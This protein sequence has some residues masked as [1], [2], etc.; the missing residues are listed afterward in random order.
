MIKIQTALI[1]VSDK[2]G[3]ARFAA[4]LSELGVQLIST[5]GTARTLQE[6]G[7]EIIR[8]SERTGF[9]EILDGRVK[10][11]HPRIHAAI[12]ARHSDADHLRTLEEL[13]IDPI[14]LVVVNLYP[15]ARTIA[16]SQV[17]RAQAIEKIDIGGPTLVR[18]AAKNSDSI[19]VVVERED[20]PRVIAEMKAGDG[21]VSLPLR[22]DLAA[23][24]F[25]HTAAY[26]AAIAA[27]LESSG[28]SQPDELPARVALNLGKVKTLRYGEN[29][30]QRAGL[31]SSGKTAGL[32]AGV[33]HQ[34]KDLSFNNLVDMDSAWQLC[35]EFD[36]T[37]CCII[38]HNNPCGAAVADSPAPAFE[39]ALECD[40]VSAFGSVIAFNHSVDGL[41]A[42][43]MSGL[44]VEVVIAPGFCAEALKIFSRKKNLRVIEMPWES[45]A[46]GKID[47]RS[48][49]GG[50]LVQDRDVFFVKGEDLRVVSKA[51]PTDDQIRDLLFS[52]I[53][54][55]HVKSNAIVLA[56]DEQT[57]GVGAGQMSRVDSVELSVRKSNLPLTGSVM[58]S[59]AFFPFSDSIEVAARVGV[60]AVIQPGGSMRDDEVIE[61]ADRHGMSMVLTG[62]RHFHH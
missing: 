18:A 43:K 27:W 10:T 9:P 35:K 11:L 61:A 21:C 23:K 4:A 38:K 45:G 52:W 15:F 36:R 53:V 51:R 33:Q 48:I 56:R 55:K 57:L 42:E 29:P 44:F 8:V 30:H 26:D 59:D 28:R 49:E 22:Q 54:C 2:K 12:L 40:P 46:S 39:R 6:A 31:Y 19:T 20:Y 41:T 5:G 62:I 60:N 34:G 37:T 7:L 17:T 50:F 13:E 16:R 25:Q 47:I 3:V 24:A 58:A 1:S 32:P 14:E